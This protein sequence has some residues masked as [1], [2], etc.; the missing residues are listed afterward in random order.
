MRDQRNNNFWA[1][2]F[3]CFLIW[4][5]LNLLVRGFTFV[6]KTIFMA[7]SQLAYLIAIGIKKLI[8]VIR[9]KLKQLKANYTQK[10]KPKINTG[11]P[12]MKEF[13]SN[14]LSN[15]KSKIASFKI[16]SNEYSRKRT[17]KKEEKKKNKALKKTQK[18][19]SYQE[20]DFTLRVKKIKY[21]IIDF[22]YT[23]EFQI[24][25]IG[26]LGIAIVIALIVLNVAMK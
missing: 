5:L 22:F 21:C 16:K 13:F 1:D 3:K 10:Y 25:I 11:F 24:L 17:E 9:A 20:S 14:I 26:I 19:R 23:Y 12:E 8:L 4:N 6:C 18:Q 2:V 7:L 15:F